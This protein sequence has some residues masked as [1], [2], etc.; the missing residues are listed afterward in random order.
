VRTGTNCHFPVLPRQYAAQPEKI[1][2]KHLILVHLKKF[3]INSFKTKV[4]K[5]SL[6]RHVTN[7]GKYSTFHDHKLEKN[8]IK[9][10]EIKN[11]YELP[12]LNHKSKEASSPL[13]FFKTR[14]HLILF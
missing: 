5:L 7:P 2:N 4:S 3:F 12:S 6:I 10:Y 8:L 9:N 11:C 1:K 13:G 14:N